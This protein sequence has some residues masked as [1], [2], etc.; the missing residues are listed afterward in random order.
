MVKSTRE[1]QNFDNTIGCFLRVESIKISLNKTLTLGALSKQIH[2][3][4]IDT[5]PH[6]QCSSLVKIA[7]VST[8]YQKAKR[9]RS[10]LIHSFTYV[11]T[12][13]LRALKLNRKILNLCGRLALYERD[14]HFIINI[15]VQPTILANNKRKNKSNL[16]VF[17]YIKINEQKN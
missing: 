2:H 8:F 17:R 7:S 15:N 9:L 16:F 4:T 11:Y 3:A 14:N 1:D 5:A 12:K 10:Y 6:Q 13:L